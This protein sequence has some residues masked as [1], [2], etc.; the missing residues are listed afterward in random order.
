MQVN[1]IT[2]GDKIIVMVSDAAGRTASFESQAR[3]LV[4]GNLLVDPFLQNGTVIGFGKGNLAIDM[5]VVIEDQ[6]PQ[7][8]KNVT[9]HRI[10]YMDQI[11][12]MITTSAVGVKMNRRSHYRLFLGEDAKVMIGQYPV[13][14][15]VIK[16]ISVGG[17]AVVISSSNKYEISKHMRVRVSF[18]DTRS[19][20]TFDLSGRIIRKLDLENN[21]TLYGCVLD[22]ESNAIGKFIATRQTELRNINRNQPLRK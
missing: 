14:T 6:S 15:G 1:E 5:L 2:E 20:S 22:H 4:D 3:M 17:F 7:L 9:I 12:H 16:D 13:V 21:T 19:S 8:F 11:Y 18:T 10:S